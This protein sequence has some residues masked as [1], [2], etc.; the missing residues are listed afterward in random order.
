M[1]LTPARCDRWLA[2]YFPSC[3]PP[4]FSVDNLSS[5]VCSVKR[6]HGAHT[7]PSSKSL[8]SVVLFLSLGRWRWHITVRL[9]RPQSEMHR[10]R[11]QE[12]LALPRDAAL[13]PSLA[14]FTAATTRAVRIKSLHLKSILLFPHELQEMGGSG[15]KGNIKTRKAGLVCINKSGF[16]TS[17]VKGSVDR[18]D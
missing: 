7:S 18:T 10:G 14:L 5:C 17:T 13:K 6:P 12:L 2:C 11:H 16:L 15:R 1:L 9:M 4:P 3:T 8:G